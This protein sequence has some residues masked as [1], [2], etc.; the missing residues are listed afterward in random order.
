MMTGV[1]KNALL[2]IFT[3]CGER[4]VVA[5]APDPSRC[6]VFTDIF[7][8]TPARG[9]PGAVLCHVMLCF[10]IALLVG[11]PCWPLNKCALTG[12][13]VEA[14]LSQGIAAQGAAAQAIEPMG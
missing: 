7:S 1:S 6:D 10:A 12:I 4:I 2:F 14:R 5:V 11:S 8:V 13:A 3:K 9:S